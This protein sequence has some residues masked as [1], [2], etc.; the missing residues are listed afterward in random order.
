MLV[1]HLRNTAVGMEPFVI[2]GIVEG[3]VCQQ[4]CSDTLCVYKRLTTIAF[5]CLLGLLGAGMEG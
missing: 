2:M 4:Q 1:G 3:R 5:G